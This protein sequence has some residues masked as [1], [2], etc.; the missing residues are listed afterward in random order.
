MNAARKVVRIEKGCTKTTEVDHMHANRKRLCAQNITNSFSHLF[1]PYLLRINSVSSGSH[2]HLR[3]L[4]YAILLI[5]FHK[6]SF[7]FNICLKS[8][9]SFSSQKKPRKPS[10]RRRTNHPYPHIKEVPGRSTRTRGPPSAWFFPLEEGYFL[11]ACPNVSWDRDLTP[12]HRQTR[13][14]TLP[15]LI[16]SVWSVIRHRKSYIWQ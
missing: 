6:S 13:L 14:K 15:S 7:S 10:S 12:L 8:N 2:I 16:L 9:H 5:G 3:V 1:V 4:I 11:L